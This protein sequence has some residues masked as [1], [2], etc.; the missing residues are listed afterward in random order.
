LDFA[1]E[2]TPNKHSQCKA[3]DIR[4]TFIEY[5]CG[6]NAHQK[7]R[8]NRSVGEKP[9]LLYLLQ[10]S[11]VTDEDERQHEREHSLEDHDLSLPGKERLFWP[12]DLDQAGL[13]ASSY[14]R[15]QLS[16]IV[17]REHRGRDVNH[18]VT[19]SEREQTLHLSGQCVDP[20]LQSTDLLL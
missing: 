14:C 17:G 13:D 8:G 20:A 2:G 1:L 19:L 4:R 11:S 9:P 6:H 15:L 7:A 18:D 16:N 10:L 12:C 5:N 3:H